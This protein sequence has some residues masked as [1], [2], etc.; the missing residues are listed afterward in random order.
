LAITATTT[1]AAATAAAATVSTAATIAAA[2]TAAAIAAAAGRPLFT[3]AGFV[4]GQRP[5]L[6]VLGVKHLNGLFRL[7]FRSHFDE[8]KTA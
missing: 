2:A 1:T 7:L 8:G 6:E 3:R 4:N 5:A